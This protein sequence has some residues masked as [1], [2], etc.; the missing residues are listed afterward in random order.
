[1]KIF[2]MQGTTNAG[3][4]AHGRQLAKDLG[5]EYVSSGD[6]ARGLMDEETKAEFAEGKLSPHDAEI[7]RAIY[8]RIVESRA[9]VVLDGFPRTAAHVIDLILWLEETYGS[10]DEQNCPDI[11]VVRLDVAVPVIVARVK[12][13]ARDEFDTAEVALKRHAVYIDDTA[14]AFNFLASRPNVSLV[15]VTLPQEASFDSVHL[16]LLGELEDRRLA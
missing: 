9:G 16:A 14:T 5:L 7:R 8:D 10:L 12:A 1:M 4:T 13:R 2:V 6:I 3:K 15:V 11:C